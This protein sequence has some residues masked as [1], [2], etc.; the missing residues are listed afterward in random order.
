MRTQPPDPSDL[1]AHHHAAL[2]FAVS[3][4]PV[5]FYSAAP[6][7]GRHLRFVS[8]NVETI[9]GHPTREFLSRDG[10]IEDL[11]HPEDR[12]Q[13]DRDAV[14]LHSDGKV[15]GTCRLRSQ[16][17]TYLRFRHERR[18]AECADGSFEIAGCL[19]DM[20]GS[21]DA[22]DAPDSLDDQ[23]EAL[24]RPVVE[25][26]PVP[27]AMTRAADGEV[28]Y[29]SP[30]TRALLGA[31]QNG[32]PKTW[33]ALCFS[34]LEGGQ[35]LMARLRRDRRLD[36][37]ELTF[38]RADGTTFP[39]AVAARVID[40][41]GEDVVVSVIHDLSDQV[42]R[43][44]QLRLARETLEDAIESLSEGLVLYDANDRLVLCNSQ[45]KAFNSDCA[46]L[47]VPGATWPE[48]TKRRAERGFFTAASGGLEDWLA[49]QMAQ[50]G[51]ARREEFLAAGGRWYDYSHRPTRQGGFVSTWRDITKRKQME[52]A[53]RDSEELVRRIL[54]ACPLPV[55]MWD[56]KSGQVLYE[57]PACQE[58]LGRDATELSPEQRLSAYVNLE[59][60]ELY[61]ARL[62][63]S[64]AVDNAEMELRRADGSTFW[65]AVSARIA[66]FQDRQVVVSS[67]VDLTERR[68]A[69]A[70]LARQRELL[71]QSEKLSALGELL[72]GVSHELNNPLSVLVGQ[73]LLLKETSAD[74]QL[75][76]RANRIGDAANRCAR[77]VKS[78]LAMARQEPLESRAVDIAEVIGEAL[79]VTA[80]FL[81]SSDIDVSLSLAE[82]L[83]TVTADPGQLRQVLTNLIVNAQ[84]ALQSKDGDRKLCVTAAYDTQAGPDP[85]QD[86]GQRP[87][88]ARG[89]EGANLRSALHHQGSRQRNRHGLGDL[90]PGR[91]VAWRHADARARGRPRRGLRAPPA[92]ERPA[93]ARAPGRA[94][95][96][97]VRPA[98]CGFWWSTTIS[99]SARS[100][101][102]SWNTRV[103]SQR[104]PAPASRRSPC[105]PRTASTWS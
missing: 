96:G 11:M 57:S 2:A 13:H 1:D 41:L 81:R 36:G 29:E 65:A 49:G 61:L 73:A 74:P 59:D 39:G 102:R 35:E 89:S 16:R 62:R 79:D 27:L 76:E 72:A 58:M 77:I 80:Y 38:R 8:A 50:R 88:R 5:I 78:F 87:R 43:R 56:P 82:D 25:A 47:L 42:L 92:G 104:S 86:R 54:E 94:R 64:G 93:G 10:F 66:D 71:F 32:A 69:D 44:E 90:P 15:T 101:A 40:H 4:S 84:H 24:I 100:S 12:P 21:D 60:R 103:T 70:E 33:A 105:W 34:E 28:I 9:I 91:R 97:W 18:L 14:A 3:H 95:T 23:I 30:A 98:A 7:G 85:G 51:I 53:L 52:Q 37:F 99:S 68:A 63:A 19:V 67:I 6:D 46:D 45:Y 17:G 75:V 22:K 26:C 83:P 31:R 48:V 20:G 55:R